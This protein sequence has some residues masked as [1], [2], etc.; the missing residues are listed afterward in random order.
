M[1][2]Q[3]IQKTLVNYWNEEDE[4]FVVLSPLMDSIIGVGDTVE[5]A[6]KE[7][8]RILSDAYEAYLEGRM[9]SSD[10]AGRPTKNRV[11]LNCDVKPKTREHIKKMASE[12]GSSQGEVIDYLLGSYLYSKLAGVNS[13]S[14]D[15]LQSL[16]K[17]IAHEGGKI[18]AERAAPGGVNVARANSIPRK[19]EELERRLANIEKVVLKKSTSHH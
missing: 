10:Q 2:K 9:G 17:E 7:F 16:Y 14:R 15:S 1:N 4:C 12:I 5:E 3:A 13:K 19:V 8:S 6:E 18:V 11:S